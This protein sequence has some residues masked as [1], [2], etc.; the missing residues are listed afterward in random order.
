MLGDRPSTAPRPMAALYDTFAPPFPQ[1][2]F[3]LRV[4]FY[5]Y[6]VVAV[7]RY[8]FGLG[9]I[10]SVFG[11]GSFDVF[12]YT[13]PYNIGHAV[14]TDEDV[15]HDGCRPTC[16]LATEAQ[17]PALCTARRPTRRLTRPRQATSSTRPTPP[18]AQVMVSACV[19]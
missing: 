5:C 17:A 14:Q 2:H 7:H 6:E 11:K 9:N 10:R 8:V 4:M 15:A 12:L 3:D 13:A 1:R 16:P 18:M 19:G